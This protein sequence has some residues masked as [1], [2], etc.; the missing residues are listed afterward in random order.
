MLIKEKVVPYFRR[1]VALQSPEVTTDE[2]YVFTDD[3]LWD[4]L[5]MSIWEHNPAY[6]EHSFPQNEL[7]F[8]ILLGRKELY[9]RLAT[10]SAPFYPLSAEGAEL[11][12][13]YRFEHYMALIRVITKEYD[14]LMERYRSNM[15][16]EHGVLLKN[17]CQLRHLQYNDLEP[18][19]FSLDSELDSDSLILRWTKFKCLGDKF[20]SYKVYVSDSKLDE[21]TNL[22]ELTPIIEETDIHKTTHKLSNL[23]KELY[24]FLIVHEGRSGLKGYMTL[25]VDLRGDLDES[26]GS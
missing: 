17:K 21:F 14:S 4:I 3:E 8:L 7:P 25:E 15:G 12:K 22:D 23:A 10:V 2:A 20:W 5:L 18:P 6:D 26:S 24:H 19:T 1:A 11:R 13:D 16:V 9:Y